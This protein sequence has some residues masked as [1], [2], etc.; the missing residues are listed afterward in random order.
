MRAASCIAA[1]VMTIPC[2]ADCYRPST[3]SNRRV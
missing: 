3:N 2:R 1:K